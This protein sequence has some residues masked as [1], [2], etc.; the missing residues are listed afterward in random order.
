MMFLIIFIF[1]TSSIENEPFSSKMGRM[2]LVDSL[3]YQDQ[4]T[5][6]KNCFASVYSADDSKTFGYFQAVLVLGFS[7]QTMSPGYD[8][9]LITDIQLQGKKQLMPILRKAWT[10]IIYRSPIIIPN[11]LSI[12]KKEKDHL[13]KLHCWSL[14]NY[15]KVIFL[16][17]DTLLFSSIS[18]LFDVPAPSASIDYYSLEN[19]RRYPLFNSD[20]MIINPNVPDYLGLLYL[21]GEYILK[22]KKDNLLDKENNKKISVRFII[23][24]YFKKSITIINFVFS[25]ENGGEPN[26]FYGDP[27]HKYFEV[28]TKSVHFGGMKPWLFVKS[29]VYMTA[30]NAIA[31]YTYEQLDVPFSSSFRTDY[32]NQFVQQ[33]MDIRSKMNTK[34]INIEDNNENEYNNDIY[35]SDIKH[36]VRY[37]LSLIF[38]MLFGSLL[39]VKSTVNHSN[40]LNSFVIKMGEK[41]NEFVKLENLNE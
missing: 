8:R 23:N 21:T 34:I 20:F 26:T 13:F 38:L 2:N 30:W 39:F 28:M 15:S 31:A 12:S 7:L 22:I 5:S 17:A 6:T 16:G 3:Q 24:E 14:Q 37:V 33:Y 36:G 10:H 9:V 27:D 19:D 35:P 18:N 1:N 32:S 11:N 4:F 41:I 25:H 29:S 40:S